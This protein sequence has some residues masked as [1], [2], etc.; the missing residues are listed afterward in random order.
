MSCCRCAFLSYADKKDGKMRGA[1]YF[2][3]KKKKYVNGNDSACAYYSKDY[4]RKSHEVNEIYENGR[5][6]YNDETNP[7]VYLVILIILIILAI[8]VNL[9]L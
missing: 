5:D 1:V 7:G 2:C 3:K 4:S 6:Y 8:I 9:V